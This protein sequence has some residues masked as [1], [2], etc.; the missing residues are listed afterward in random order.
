MPRAALLAILCLAIGA[1]GCGA[2]PAS[3]G[4][5]PASAVPRDAAVYLDATVRPSGRLRDDALAAAAK[6]LGTADPEGEI[7]RLVARAFAES[8]K[9]E[10]DYG[11]DVEPW[12]GEKVAL[13]AV[14]AGG[15]EEFRGAVVASATDADAARAA[16]DRAV[17]GSDKTFSRRTYEGVDYRAAAGSAAGVV[18]DFAVFGTEAEFKRTVDAVKGDGLD[19][20][21][22]FRAATGDLSDD[23]LGTFYVDLRA[24]IDQAGRRDPGAAEQIRQAR[25]LLPLKEIGPVAGAF[26]ADGER[27]A[28]DA[29]ADVPEGGALGALTRGGATSARPR[30]PCTSSPRA[31]S[32][33]PRSRSSSGRSSGSTCRRTSSAGSATRP[34]SRAGRRR[35]LLTAAS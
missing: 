32:G 19:S 30:R 34:S 27:L 2:G 12:L 22:R 14:P 1:A 5:D 20:D 11:R 33:A 13:W 26:T 6:I 8:S 21:D 4:D 31:R 25:R 17:E 16:I 3:G 28:V 9:P 10:L 23:R 29:V 24:A 18:E 7:D 15:D 35:P